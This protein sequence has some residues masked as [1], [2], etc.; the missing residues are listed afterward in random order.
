MGFYLNNKYETELRVNSI[1]MPAIEIVN[2]EITSFN[3]AEF[4]QTSDLGYIVNE[5]DSTVI[6][7]EDITKIPENKTGKEIELES[8]KGDIQQRLYKILIEYG[9]G[10]SEF[11]I[12]PENDEDKS[13][14]TFNHSY[15]FSTEDVFNNGRR[16]YYKNL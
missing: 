11:H 10:S 4:I 13:W 5:K 7:I 3:F 15:L 14:L 2:N 1:S 12:R 16:N 6:L 8:S 9:D